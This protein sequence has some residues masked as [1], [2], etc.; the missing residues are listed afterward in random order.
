M[1]DTQIKEKPTTVT[2]VKVNEPGQYKVIYMNDELN[3]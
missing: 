3:F 2:Q 1:S